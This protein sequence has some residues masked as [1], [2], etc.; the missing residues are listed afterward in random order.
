MKN[1][2]LKCIDRDTIKYIAAIPM[3][4][5]HFTGFVWAGRTNPGDSLLLFLLT[6]TALIAPPIF[7][8]FIAEGFRYT[9]S[10]KAYALRL[11]IFAAAAQITFCLTTS[12]TLFTEDFFFI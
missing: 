11:L 8:F 12:G 1:I 5:G 4:I 7:F 9:H 3:A 6:Q 2:R 10:A